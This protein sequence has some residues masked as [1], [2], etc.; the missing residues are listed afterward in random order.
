MTNARTLL[1]IL[2]MIMMKHYACAQSSQID[3]L[4]VLISKSANDTNRINL[5]VQKA[6]LLNSVNLDSSILVAKQALQQA[7]RI[8]Y[9]RGQSEL[10]RHISRTYAIK[11]DFKSAEINLSILK[12]LLKSSKDS[13]DI[14]N[15]YGGYGDV[16]CIQG[17]FDTSIILLTKA[18]GIIERNGYTPSLPGYYANLGTAYRQQ[19]N[20]PEALSYQQAAL[21]LFEKE[22]NYTQGAITLVN[23]AATYMDVGD[24]LKS[25]QTYERAIAIA[26]KNNLVRVEVY[27]YSN[28]SSNLIDQKNWKKSYEYAMKAV[29]LSANSGDLA[30]QAASLSKAAKCLAQMNQFDEAI[31]LSKQAIAIADSV[32]HQYVIAQAYSGMSTTLVKQKK[33]KEAIPF[34]KKALASLSEN[35]FNEFTASLYGELVECYQKTGDPAEAL[36][37]FILL[38]RSKDSTRSRENI[39]KATELSMNYDFA[40][41]QAVAKALQDRKDADVKRTKKQQQLNILALGILLLTALIIAVIQYRSNKHKRKANLLL[42]QE[43]Q[44]VEST[45]SELKSTQ[46]QLIQSEKMASLGEL[47]AGIAHEIQNP[48]NFVNN[49]SDVNQELLAEMKDEIEKGNTGEAQAIANDV[50]QNEQRINHHGKRADAIVKGMLQHSRKSS[51]QKEPTDINALADEYLRLSYHGL[52]AKDKTFNAGMKTDFDGSVGKINIIPQDIGRVLLNLFNNA[53]YACA[54]R[55]RSAVNAQ[56]SNNFFSYEPAVSVATKSVDDKVQIIVKDNGNGI[57]QNIVDKIFQPFFTTKPTGEGTGLGLSLAYDIIKAHG[58]ELKVE[59]RE[60]EGT[61]FII[62]FPTNA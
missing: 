2:L 18:V 51:G 8:H 50:I 14:A 62:L 49:F 28:L 56:K 29:A 61:T 36:A 43:K 60:G 45:L 11:G 38:D 5:F 40:K 6:N 19:A 23:M 54:E 21:D 55:S 9:L 3:S 13:I 46:A 34:I 53:F 35:E 1:F 4:N 10:I 33:Y 58:A 59:S 22:N 15:M 26:E 30:I 31:K 27:S 25:N 41:K 17:R 39:Q 24:T 16:Y 12:Q 57:P 52:R 47:T 32:G 44:K 42:Q 7:V 37:A 48:L 20:Y